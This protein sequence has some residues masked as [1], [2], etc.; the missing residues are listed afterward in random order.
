MLGYDITFLSLIGFVALTGIVVN[1]S[2]ILMQ[3][4]NEQREQGTGVFDSLVSAGRH[5]LR[6]ILLTTITTVLGLTPL[7][8]EQSFQAKF[9]IPMA[10]SIAI[11]LISATVL[12]LIA[13]PCFVLIY[14]D[15]RRLVILVW[16]GRVDDATMARQAT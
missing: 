4:Y 1:D 10:I 9:L 16:H 8:L 14:E 11:G 15:L 2:L 7:L 5:R 3:F 13:L 12:V 6:A